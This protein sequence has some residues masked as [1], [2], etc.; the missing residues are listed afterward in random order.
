MGEPR[1]QFPR[2]SADLALVQADAGRLFS[3]LDDHAR[4]SSHMGKRSWMMGGGRMQLHFD[5]DRGQAIGSSLEL[6]GRAFGIAVALREIVTERVP[7]T[8][9]VWETAGEPRLL[10]IGAYRMGFEI[11][12]QG[13]TSLL[14]VFI[15]YA[16][17]SRGLARWLGRA[18]GP[19]YA[20]WCTRRMVGDAVVHFS[21]RPAGPSP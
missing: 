19:G 16:L 18:L 17:P 6:S 20:R 10:V 13:D 1:R 9:K 14:R 3:Y 5:A 7:P 2:A 4:L 11:T 12:A 8:R 21:P 15:E